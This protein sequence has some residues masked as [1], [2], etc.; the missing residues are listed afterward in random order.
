MVEE[1][2]NEALPAA[3]AEEQTF[4]TT[5][6]RALAAW[7]IVSVVSSFLIAAWLILPFAGNNKLIGAF[8]VGLAF[9]LMLMSHRAR[10][11]TASALGWRM[12]NF[13]QAARWLALPMLC[14]AALILIV[15]WWKGSLRFEML[16]T[17]PRFLLLPIWALIQQYVLQSFINR[18]A[19]LIWGP[20][21]RS[22]LL[23]GLLFAL[24]HSPNPWLMVATFVGGVIW[25]AVYQRV[26]NLFALALSHSAMS[27]L[28]ALSLPSSIL[29]SLRVG[30]KY[31]S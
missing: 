5:S 11:E 19:Q 9:V 26:P 6:D 1:S 28:L 24:L 31:F 4:Y 20:G 8:P 17:R 13:W 22:V 12:D 10:G 18:R 21:I 30:F 16:L 7:E 27:L 3:D 14:A 29:N 23:V 15:G 25:A 2:P